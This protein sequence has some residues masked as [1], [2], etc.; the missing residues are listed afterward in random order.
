MLLIVHLCLAP[1]MEKI[2]EQRR[3]FEEHRVK[4]ERKRQNKEQARI[5][6]AEN[7][8]IRAQRNNFIYQSDRT[9]A[10]EQRHPE[11]NTATK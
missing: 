11:D 4:A 7:R 9:A 1:A 2:A 8:R 10:S 6:A 5:K 3:R